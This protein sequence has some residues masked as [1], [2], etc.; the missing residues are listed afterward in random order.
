MLEGNAIGL[1]DYGM[2]GRIDEQLHDSLGEMLVALSELDPEYLTSII[3]RVGMTP[4][5]LD[6][7][8]L[9]AD[10]S[11]FIFHYASQLLDNV[12]LGD[13]LQELIEI[14]RRH[15]I[16]LP[17]RMAMLLKTLITLEGT[18]RL[19]NPRFSL[20]DVMRPYRRTILRR[21][22]SPRRK[23]RKLR[24]F[25]AEMAHLVETLP[26]NI[27]EILDQVQR[28]KF[29]VHLDHRGLE[30]SVNRLVLGL[31]ASAMFVGSSMMISSDVPP[32]LQN[33]PL[34]GSFLPEVS[35]PGV[36]G[37]GFSLALGLRLWRAIHKSGHLDRRK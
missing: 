31:L 11:D 12:H 3:V 21:H 27:G 6:R 17:A 2:V 23:F 5:E 32:M 33:T 29:D 24:R 18:G 4:A 10:M 8:V 19:L 35:V 9:A 20:L 14:I 36:I 25:Y 15:H 1:L 26:Q 28:G 37:I 13:A 34:I 7:S 16:G 30:P 22:L